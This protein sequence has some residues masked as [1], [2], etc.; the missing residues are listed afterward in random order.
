M[1]LC[2]HLA[3]GRAVKHGKQPLQ[4]IVVQARLAPARCR[5]A[6]LLAQS[7]PGAAQ[8]LATETADLA[9]P[10]PGRRVQGALPIVL[11]QLLG[12]AALRSSRGLRAASA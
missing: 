12:R 9:G 7:W 5:L 10:L 1:L 6:H 2:L 8:T 3:A 4:T 11:C